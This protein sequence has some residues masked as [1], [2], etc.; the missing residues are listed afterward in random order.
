[1]YNNLNGNP[2]PTNTTAVA[3]SGYAAGRVGARIKDTGTPVRVKNCTYA[4]YNFFVEQYNDPINRIEQN[5]LKKVSAWLFMDIRS[6]KK[7][8]FIA[9]SSNIPLVCFFFTAFFFKINLADIS[10]C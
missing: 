1:M 3:V 6:R 4:E 8:H 2:Q 10:Y 7:M 9:M 5:F